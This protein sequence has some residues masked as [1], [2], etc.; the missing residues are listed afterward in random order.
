MLP[1]SPFSRKAVLQFPTAHL[2]LQ[3]YLWD[4]IKL[5]CKVIKIEP[6]WGDL[7][8]AEGTF[9]TPFGIL[10][11]RHE[12][13]RDGKVRSAI[14]APPGVQIVGK[15]PPKS[16]PPDRQP[17][18]GERRHCAA[19]CKFARDARPRHPTP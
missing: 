8:R 11:V 3:D 9:P 2:N 1:H 4:G 15:W 14:D 7:K 12:S 13:Q 19:P 6:H 16:R 10:K 5:G 17:G 18:R